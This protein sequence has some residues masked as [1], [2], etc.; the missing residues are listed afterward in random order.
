MI[1]AVFW[2]S[3]PD[4]TLSGKAEPPHVLRNGSKRRMLCGALAPPGAALM[5]TI[6]N[7]VETP[8]CAGCL[9]ALDPEPI[10]VRERKNR[11]TQPQVDA[12]VARFL[13]AGGTILKLSASVAPA[14]NPY[15]RLWA[16]VDLKGHTD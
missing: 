15:R 5:P 1:R 3:Q 4:R 8:V 7:P 14:V 16:T 6:F 11:I 12:A 9:A 2:D 13:A 10:R